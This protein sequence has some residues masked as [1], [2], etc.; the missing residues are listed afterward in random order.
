MPQAEV[1]FLVEAC[2]ETGGFVARWDDPRGGGIT[3]QGDTLAELHTMLTDA[4][5]GYFDPGARPRRVRLHFAED[6]V[7]ALG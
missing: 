3:T 2:S 5:R 4:V 6:P 7:L 1:T